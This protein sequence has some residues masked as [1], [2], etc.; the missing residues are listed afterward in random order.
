MSRS[1]RVAVDDTVAGRA[2]NFY[3]TEPDRDI[4]VIMDVE[5]ASKESTIFSGRVLF[6]TNPKS[7]LRL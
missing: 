5:I 3:D 7:N 1:P 2:M 6:S 4:N